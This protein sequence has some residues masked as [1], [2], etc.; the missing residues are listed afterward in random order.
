VRWNDGAAAGGV[1]VIALARAG[2]VVTARTGS[3]GRY[4]LGPLPAGAITLF[5]SRKEGLAGM[6]SEGILPD[7]L[8]RPGSRVTLQLSAND[9]RRDLDLAL[10]R[11]GVSIR[12]VVRAAD[13]APLAGARVVAEEQ[14][15]G[16]GGKILRLIERVMG[17]TLGPMGPPSGLSDAEGRFAIDDLLPGKY[18]VRAAFPGMPDVELGAVRAGR[19]EV[20]LR[21]PEGVA[22]TGTVVRADGSPVSDGELVVRRAGGTAETT[23]AAAVE[24]L[25]S[26]ARLVVHDPRG[27]FRLSALAPGRYE[28]R[29]TDAAGD[30]GKQAIDVSGGTPAREVRLVVGPGATV[31]GRVIDEREGTP[32]AAAMV[33]VVGA[34]GMIARTSDG[35]GRFTVQG[36]IPGDPIHL[37]IGH[38]GH[39]AATRELALPAAG[40]RDLGDVRLGAAPG[41]P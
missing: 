6:F 39:A 28:L 13:G 5:A 38:Q 1:T 35:D 26:A 33:A 20:Q 22:V 19:G 30:A 9:A 12:G 18:L 41:R 29:F 10:V 11:G 17:A 23:P 14:S 36:L 27:G 16:T 15:L 4:T 31:T 25:A 3:D 2:A 37:V 34:G 40:T 32:L 21:F 24:L 8:A 7:D